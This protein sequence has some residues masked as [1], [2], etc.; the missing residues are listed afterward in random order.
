M[1]AHV[2]MEMCVLKP[3][4]PKGREQIPFEHRDVHFSVV[5]NDEHMGANWLSNVHRRRESRFIVQMGYSII[6]NMKM[7]NYKTTRYMETF[8][9]S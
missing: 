8:S 3:L 6:I 2:P 1:W 5:C 4:T 9:M 7:Y